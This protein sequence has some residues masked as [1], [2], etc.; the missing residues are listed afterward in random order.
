M[1][2]G[3]VAEQEGQRQHVELGVDGVDGAA[4]VDVDRAGADAIGDRPSSPSWALG[5]MDDL[6]R[7]LVSSATSAAKRSTALLIRLSM[8]EAW[9]R[10]E[11]GLG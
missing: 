11:A 6:D 3:G 2:A 7:A 10:R 5:K 9:A 8:E 1:H 4:E